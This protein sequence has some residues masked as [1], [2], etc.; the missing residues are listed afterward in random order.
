M[1]LYLAGP[2]RGDIDANITAARKVAIELWERGYTVICPH[3]NTAH[4]E[5]DCNLPESEYIRRDLEI[6]S[7][8]DAI[9]ML[10]GWEKSEGA[11]A[12]LDYALIDRDDI[13]VYYSADD[14]DGVM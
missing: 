1:V 2:Y 5:V 3:L 7:R 6:L 4:F 13:L 10:P 12:E 14:L 9:V 8:C 11:C